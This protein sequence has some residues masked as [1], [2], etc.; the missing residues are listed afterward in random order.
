MLT[1]T[2]NITIPILFG[3]PY[4]NVITQCNWLWNWQMYQIHLMIPVGG[5]I[6]NC[7]FTAYSIFFDFHMCSAIL[8]D[9]WVL[10]C[11]FPQAALWLLKE[12]DLS[13]NM[14]HR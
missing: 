1:V 5:D 2:V 7:Y 13:I 8:D 6:C 4:L 14:S 9:P 3:L 12:P 10:I 11:C